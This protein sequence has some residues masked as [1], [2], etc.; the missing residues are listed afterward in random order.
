MIIGILGCLGDVWAQYDH[1]NIWR[2][3]YVYDGDTFL[4][5]QGNKKVKFRLIGINT[6][7][8][9]H[10]FNDYTEEPYNQEATDYLKSLIHYKPVR[11]YYDVQTTDG[12][13]RDLVY[14]FSTDKKTFINAELLKAGLAELMTIPPNVAQVDTFTVLYRQAITEGRGM[15]TH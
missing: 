6:P 1:H 9:A 4:A 3:V 12:S 15:W 14:V 2:V 10:K 11:V 8:K 13:D 7:E 5:K